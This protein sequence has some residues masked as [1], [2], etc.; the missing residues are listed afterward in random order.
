[1]KDFKNIN[2]DFKH[3]CEFEEKSCTVFVCCQ[4][5]VAYIPNPAAGLQIFFV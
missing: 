4:T 2:F 3:L 1:M 5:D